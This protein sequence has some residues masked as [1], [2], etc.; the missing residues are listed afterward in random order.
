MIVILKNLQD[1]KTPL[2]LAATFGQLDLM[3]ILLSRGA[4][5][6]VIDEVE[7]EYQGF[8]N[9]NGISFCDHL[10]SCLKLISSNFDKLTEWILSSHAGR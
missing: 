2:M 6:D 10:P 9:T 3:E 7:F 5:L 4:K 1:G 8:Q